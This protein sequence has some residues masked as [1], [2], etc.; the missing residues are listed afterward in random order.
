MPE[1]EVKNPKRVNIPP[2]DRSPPKAEP[3]PAGT[4]IVTGKLIGPQRCE[5]CEGLLVTY[6]AVV[7]IDASTMKVRRMTCSP[8]FW[9]R[10]CEAAELHEAPR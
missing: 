3:D 5:S 4:F 2:P 10:L 1:T 6:G 8:C 7:S 9:A